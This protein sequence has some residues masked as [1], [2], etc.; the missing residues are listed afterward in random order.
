MCVNNN[1]K[2]HSSES[3][4]G[5]GKPRGSLLLGRGGISQLPM[6]VA[7]LGFTGVP[8]G[9]M[10]SSSLS[11]ELCGQ[12]VGVWVTVGIDG[13]LISQDHIRGDP[14]RQGWFN[15]WPS[16]RAAAQSEGQQ[17]R[18]RLQPSSVGYVLCSA[19]Q[20]CLSGAYRNP[21]K[22]TTQC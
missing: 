1:D 5:Y 22:P 19:P 21:Q 20:G 15:H 2:V 7:V 4:G 9:L 14:C 3:K 16:V 18:N 11:Q 8:H 17:P 13:E 10:E 6:G 12:R